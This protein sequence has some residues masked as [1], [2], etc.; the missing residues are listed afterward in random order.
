MIVFGVRF[1][2]F[3]EL[4]H[5]AQDILSHLRRTF[6]TGMAGEQLFKA[7]DSTFG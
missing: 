6:F 2:Q 4:F 7:L 5:L 1:D 3:H